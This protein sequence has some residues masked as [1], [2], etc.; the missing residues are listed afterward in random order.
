MDN[1]KVDLQTR[2]QDLILKQE[3]LKGNV[4]DLGDLLAYQHSPSNYSL[5]FNSFKLI[6]FECDL[7]GSHRNQLKISYV[8]LTAINKQDYPYRDQCTFYFGKIH[9]VNWVS[10]LKPMDS[11]LSFYSSQY[12][13][14]WVLL[15]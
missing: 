1:T 11:T 15:E 10:E 7:F 13:K 4:V 3:V 2:V 12:K 9:D 6:Y 5:G 8:K 14:K